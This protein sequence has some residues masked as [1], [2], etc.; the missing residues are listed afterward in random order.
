MDEKEKNEK[1]Q[2]PKKEIKVI[3]GNGDDLNISPV[4]EHIKS[5]E[6]SS[7]EKKKN[8]IIPKRISEE[9]ED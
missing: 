2:N 3:N 7:I 1:D 8:I 5:D 4:Y 9:K 6:D